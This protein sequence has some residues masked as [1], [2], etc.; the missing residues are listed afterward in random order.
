MSNRGAVSRRTPTIAE[1]KVWTYGKLPY[2]FSRSTMKSFGQTLK[3]F[4]V[5]RSPQGNIFIYAPMTDI[6]GE[7]HG[8]TFRQYFD[9]DLL[10]HEVLETLEDIKEYISEH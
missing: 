5:K 8:W 10:L 2:F 4:T 9:G 6:G 1:I 3:S 7:T